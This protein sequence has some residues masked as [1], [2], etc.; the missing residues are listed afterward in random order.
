ML[1]CLV[2]KVFLFFAQPVPAMSK[3]IESVRVSVIAIGGEGFC[4]RLWVLNDDQTF[5]L[6]VFAH[7][8]ATRLSSKV[9][10]YV[11]LEYT[12]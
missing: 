3:I 4:K 10:E 11:R 1:V 8:R 2:R 7:V 5:D 12:Y 6:T 9:E